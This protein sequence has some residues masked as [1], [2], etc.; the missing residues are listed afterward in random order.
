MKVAQHQQSGQFLFD[1]TKIKLYLSDV[2]KDRR[3]IRG[4]MLRKELAEIPVL[5]ANALDWL[6][7]NPEFIPEEWK[8][9]NSYTRAIFSG[10]RFIVIV[11][12]PF[13]SDASA[14]TAVVGSQAAFCSA[15][16]GAACSRPRCA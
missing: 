9:D 13:T 7:Q 5:N 16:T 11:L 4:H 12:A 15:V 1:P 14:G 10:G 3:Y 6:L 8:K 2:Q